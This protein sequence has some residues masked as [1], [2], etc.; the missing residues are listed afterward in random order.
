MDYKEKYEQALSRARQFSEKPLLEDSAGIVEYIFPELAESEDERIKNE[1]I[2]FVEQSIHRGGGTPI[3]Q[4]QENKWIDWLEKQGEQKPTCLL[5]VEP[6]FKVGDFV[7][8]NCD[9]VWKIEG[10]LNQFYLLEGVEGGESRPTIEWV[11][12]TFHRWTIQDAKKELKKIEQGNSPVLSN[13]SNNGKNAWSEEDEEH[14]ESILKRLD[15][16]CKKGATFT[17]TR[18]AVNQDMDWLK[19]LRDRV[20]PQSHWKPTEIQLEL[21]KEACDKRWEPDGLDPLYTLWEHLKNL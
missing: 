14:I 2:A 11:N 10:I 21:L 9:Y 7:V 19:S 3:P 20:Q 6:K 8:D 13:S 1:I 5:K 4:E 15:G 16:M 17:E 12:K 18:F